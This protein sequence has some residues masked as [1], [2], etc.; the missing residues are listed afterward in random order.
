MFTTA[1][2]L[3]SPGEGE[4]PLKHDANGGRSRGERASSGSCGAPIP[5]LIG[6]PAVD[7]S[8][9]AL[10]RLETKARRESASRETTTMFRFLYAPRTRVKGGDSPFILQ[11]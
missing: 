9:S 11:A 2:R 8:E 3:L 4:A 10:I 5:R 6:C 7:G 1:G